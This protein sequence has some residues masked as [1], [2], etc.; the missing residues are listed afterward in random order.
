MD[1]KLTVHVLMKKTGGV[2]KSS[3]NNGAGHSSGVE[4]DL[5]HYYWCSS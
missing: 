2:L 4:D 3:G 5:D 1:S